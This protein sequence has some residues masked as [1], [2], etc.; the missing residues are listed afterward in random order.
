MSGV[1]EDFDFHPPSP[2]PVGDG[3]ITE[4]TNSG[5]FW[6]G[7]TQRIGGVVRDFSDGVVRALSGARE[8]ANNVRDDPVMFWTIVW[9]LVKL[10]ALLLALYAV[11]DFVRM[12]ANRPTLSAWVADQVKRSRETSTVAKKTK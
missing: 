9:Q 6:D 3:G 8:E 4:V 5:R 7:T 2:Q 10:F 12:L 11:V 1:T